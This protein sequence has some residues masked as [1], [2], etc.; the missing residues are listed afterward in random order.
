VR[1]SDGGVLAVN[2]CG[3]A[4]G[5]FVIPGIPQ[6]DYWLKDGFAYY[7]TSARSVD[8]GFD[9]LGRPDVV[10]VD[11]ATVTGSLTLNLTNMAPW[12]TT[13]DDLQMFSA[14][15]GIGYFSTF[16]S[17]GTTSAFA[18]TSGATS[19]SNTALNFDY[20]FP[21]VQASKGDALTLVQL[22]WE[23]DGG[24]SYLS[25]DRAINR[26]NVEMTNGVPYVL[27]DSF[28][29]LTQNAVSVD[30]H[31][32][33]F[34][35]QLPHPGATDLGGSLYL[36]ALPAGLS[37]GLTS[38]TPDLAVLYT[39]IGAPDTTYAY[40]YGDP[41][42]GWPLFVTGIE[43]FS[44]DSSLPLPDGGSSPTRTDYPSAQTWQSL[45]GSSVTL[46]PLVSPA[47]NV[48]VQGHPSD[49]ATFTA[50]SDTPLIIWSASGSVDVWF[51]R[52]YHL[53]ASATL[54]SSTVVGTFII[55]GATTQMIVPPGLLQQGEWYQLRLEARVNA[56]HYDPAR[57]YL[58]D[59]LPAGSSQVLTSA[60]KAF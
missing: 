56:R 35:A 20:G 38:G 33:G 59:T 41:T 21:L 50:G 51:V 48:L 6:G 42:P 4:N 17:Y 52:L 34:V 16:N 24:L 44:V 49:G 11:G 19:V 5:T 39:L 1:F 57:P 18:P 7:L 54:T 53:T 12:N 2:A 37:H 43:T 46:A 23:T 10:L 29:P 36:D 32:T 30:Y 55:P 25:A 28:V 31:Q 22:H 15:A 3:T 45:V 8:L 60:F 14:S 40:A 27:T 47:S 9:Q 58:A 13:N 26:S